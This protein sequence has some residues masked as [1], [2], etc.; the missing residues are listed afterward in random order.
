MDDGK[1]IPS[2]WG[3]KFH[4]LGS[5]IHHALGAGA[6]GP[7]K[8]MVL[9]MDP[10]DQIMVE[11]ER[12]K[13]KHHRYFH[14]WGLST[15][16]ALHLRRTRPMLDQTIAR[17][18]RFF[19]RL[20]PGAKYNSSNTTWTFSS[21]YRY[22]FGHCKD[23]DDWDIYM[24]NE[25]THISFDEL[26]Q[27]EKEQYDQISGRIRS[28]DPV[29]RRMTKCRSATNPV[30]TGSA[31]GV[32]L[33]DPQWVRK[34]FVEPHPSGNVVL[35]KKIK[36]RAGEVKY[37]NRI[38]LPA[39]LY[40]NPDPDFIADYEA[41]LLDKPSHIRKA[42]LFG[43]WWVTAGSFYG[44]DW[45]EDLHVCSPFKIP[46]DWPIFRSMDWGFK[47]PGT[48]GWIA[49]D[50]DD[51]M[52]VFREYTFQG[53]TDREVALAIQRIEKEEGLWS[54]G[55]SLITGP[56]DT[57]LWEQR[58]DS[59]KSKGEVMAELGVPWVKAS[60]GP[61]SRESHAQLLQKRMRDHHGGH[62]VPGIVFFEDCRMCR[63]TLPG[64]QTDPKNPEC[65]ADG[66]EDHWHDM[67]LYACAYAS[68]GRGRV[69]RRRDRDPWEDE[70]AG[71]TDGRGYDGYGSS[72]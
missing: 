26:V 48:V 35:K 53:K 9:L 41:T 52:Y 71:V 13:D 61:G 45:D 68:R 27:F 72:I 69:S 20:D 50:P 6:A 18:K 23:P 25:Y 38:Y 34:H 16:W 8:S 64:V 30:Q 5:N 49:L 54:G 42:L 37:R 65:P 44:D 66:G 21:G 62:T 32:A 33:S 19:N 11:H 31:P 14:P 57:Q 29:L 40:D 1:Y 58:G 55:R 63:T 56:A 2:P 39:T 15:G 17:S 3:E 43:D 47:R 36:T 12:C 22:Q 24:S 7:G 67:V 60:K 10:T 51:N 28:S 46:H 70:V 59:A 4:R